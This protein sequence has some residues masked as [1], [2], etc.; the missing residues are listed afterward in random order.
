MIAIESFHFII[1]NLGLEI[2]R[3][4]ILL[5]GVYI[6]VKTEEQALNN[7]RK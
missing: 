4:D 5:N 6:E 1:G 3:L 7:P 2:N